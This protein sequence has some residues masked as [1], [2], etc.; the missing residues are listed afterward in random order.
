MSSGRRLAPGVL[1]G[2]VQVEATLSTRYLIQLAAAAL[3]T[4]FVT[5]LR[6]QE[7]GAPLA[8][9]R[10][11]GSIAGEVVD[12]AGVPIPGAVIRFA[13]DSQFAARD[14]QFMFGIVTANQGWLEA[15][16]P[17]YHPAEVH[18]EVPSGRY[19]TVR[20]ILV[21]D[22]SAVAAVEAADGMEA[23][24]AR[25]VLRGRVV[26][27]SGVPLRDVQ[28]LVSGASRDGVTRTDGRYAVLDL[29]SGTFMVT[30]RR[31]GYTPV[32]RTIIADGRR[33][34]ELD[35]EMSA[36]AN[37][38]AP[39]LVQGLSGWGRRSTALADLDRR[40]TSR[41]AVMSTIVSTSQL[42][43]MRNLPLN[44]ALMY[45]DAGRFLPRPPTGRGVDVD[46]AAFD[47]MMQCV[48]LNGE[49]PLQGPIA[50]YTADQVRMVEVYARGSDLTSTV[51]NR[52]AGIRGCRREGGYHPTYF[53]IWLK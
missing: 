21:P 29:P 45:S 41:Q 34:T 18:L 7:A 31:L 48:L 13:S 32:H 33:A 16:Y 19:L 22:G 14:G 15:F 6:A 46:R 8:T 51:A 5:P 1:R 50:M 30:F 40:L 23:G 43:R 3:L 53:V 11:P 12:S 10:I 17:G 27:P 52:M 44:E 4:L 2:L 24:A 47:G 28:V 37:E 9:L 36:L 25:N 26:D 38:L 35:V 39:V 49:R 42:E 20:V